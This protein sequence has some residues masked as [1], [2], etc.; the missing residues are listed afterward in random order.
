MTHFLGGPLP[1]KDPSPN[2]VRPGLASLSSPVTHLA[3]GIRSGS[4]RASSP[5]C[6]GVFLCFTVIQCPLDEEDQLLLLAFPWSQS[7]CPCLPPGL[8]KTPSSFISSMVS[9]HSCQQE[10]W[11]RHSCDRSAPSSQDCTVP[12][13]ELRVPGLQR[14]K[15]SPESLVTTVAGI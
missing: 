4:S 14:V 2:M 11:P 10:A 15:L 9:V 5:T 7:L 6:W 1:M 8:P 3:W 12:I 13:L